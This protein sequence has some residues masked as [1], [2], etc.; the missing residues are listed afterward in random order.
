ML[1]RILGMAVLILAT[2]VQAD[3][4]L[5][6]DGTTIQGTIIREGRTRVV[7]QTEFGRKSIPKR[8]I[9][10]MVRDADA[11]LPRGTLPEAVQH[12]ENLDLLSREVANA[13]ALYALGRYDEIV[14]RL[15][16]L[17]NAEDSRDEQFEL[18]WLI[19]QSHQRL[20]RFDETI[21]MLRE[22]KAGDR[23]A[24][25]IRATAYL[26]ILDQNPPDRSLRRVGRVLTRQFLSREDR[27][28]AKDP[29]ALADETLMRKALEEYCDQLLVDEKV[30]IRAVE[31]ELD[32]ELTLEAFRDLPKAASRLDQY[33]P[34]AED[35][36]NV[37]ASLDR[38]EA[39]LPGYAQSY[40]VALVRTLAM[41]L[42]E[43]LDDLFNQA[44]AEHPEPAPSGD[45]RGNLTPEERVQWREYCQEFDKALR[46]LLMIAEYARER[47]AKHPENL[48]YLNDMY[49]D[50][51]AR[52][53]QVRAT[54][55]KKRGR[56]RV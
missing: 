5:L 55:N 19:I 53:E 24:D 17:Q 48:R 3:S 40:E 44:L 46:P 4:I 6:D 28:K 32:L 33:L 13:R 38:V 18:R 30:S 14:P 1:W 25:R 26:D 12:F 23:E 41:H 21:A 47:V 45:P 34:F 27:I 9:K 10:S 50:I 35:V 49:R 15:A 43:V 8:R 36:R 29:N 22:M 52:L 37:R 16:P 11:S 20:G 42:Y 54:T 51:I 2:T 39:I 7:I 56:T 31:R